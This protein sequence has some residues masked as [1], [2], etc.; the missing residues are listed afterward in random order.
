MNQLASHISFTILAFAIMARLRTS[1]IRTSK[2]F[3]FSIILIPSAFSILSSCSSSSSGGYGAYPGAAYSDYSSYS[4]YGSFGRE[5]PHSPGYRVVETKPKIITPT[6]V[7]QSPPTK[8]LGSSKTK[9]TLGHTAGPKNFRTVIIDAGHGG[10]DSGASVAGVKEKTLALD[11]AHRLQ[12][13]LKGSFKT[14]LVRKKDTFV[15]LDGRVNFSNKF[16]DAVL[17]SIH[18]NHLNTKSVRGPETYYFRVDSYSLAKRMQ[19]AMEAI[20][21]RENARGLVRRRLRLTRNPQIPCVLVEQK[22]LLIRKNM[23]TKAWVSFLPH[24]TAHHLDLLT[25]ALSKFTFEV[26]S[27]LKSTNNVVQQV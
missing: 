22:R 13:K 26:Q 2:A 12:K 7:V 16:D 15:S 19:R 11:V 24:S 1:L 8:T 18:L 10:H 5:L 3:Y 14:I 21:P 4:D 6:E 27:T 25:L 9:S 17:V 23:V 20:S